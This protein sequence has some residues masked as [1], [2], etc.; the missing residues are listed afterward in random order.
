VYMYI[1][2]LV[3][4][5]EMQRIS[6]G[7]LFCTLNIPTKIAPNPKYL[8][9]VKFMTQLTQHFRNISIVTS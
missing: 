5:V 2:A 1:G 9:I 8:E 4:S 3:T 6:V 7:R